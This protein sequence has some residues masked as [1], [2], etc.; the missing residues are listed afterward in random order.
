MSATA[1]AYAVTLGPTV[2]TLAVSLDPTAVTVAV[3]ASL[4]TAT[5]A[6][7]LGPDA[8]ML[9]INL[10]SRGRTVITICSASRVIT[11]AAA[12][13]CTKVITDS[14]VVSKLHWTIAVIFS[15]QPVQREYVAVSSAL[16]ADI[17]WRARLLDHSPFPAVITRIRTLIARLTTYAGRLAAS[18]RRVC[19]LTARVPVLASGR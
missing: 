15:L 11:V 13:L 10:G 14:A 18:L 9:A 16:H 3:A 7:T 6:V 5:V 1:A 19:G 2:T 12:A 8:A 17:A 4:T